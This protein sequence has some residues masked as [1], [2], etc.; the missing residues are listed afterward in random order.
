MACY[1]QRQVS[2]HLL[3]GVLNKPKVQCNLKGTEVSIH[4]DYCPN[5]AESRPQ[6]KEKT[7]SKS[8]KYL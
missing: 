5:S 4:N 1:L 8:D 2:V 3:Q 7:K 6:L